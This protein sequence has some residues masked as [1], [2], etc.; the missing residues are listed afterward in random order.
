MTIA[1][2]I[3]HPEVVIDASVPVPLWRL[4]DVGRA[5]LESVM[6]EPWVR[7]VTR[8]VASGETKAIET[9]EILR[10]ANGAA[11]EVLQQIGE[12]D[13][14]ATGFLPPT[15]FEKTANEFFANP[16]VSVRG[17]ERAVDAQSRIVAAVMPVLDTPGDDVIA[18]TGHGGVGTLLYCHLAGVPIDRKHDQARGGSV[19]AIDRKTKTPLFGWTPLEDVSPR[20]NGLPSKG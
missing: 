13:R 9:A 16:H 18:F 6:P 4:S 15:E 5:R 8:F 20:L 2:Y 14:S 1:Y 10:H 19:F 3:S 17:W 12:N 11:V 7:S